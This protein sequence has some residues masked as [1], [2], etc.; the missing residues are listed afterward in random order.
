MPTSTPRVPTSSGLSNDV[1]Q[2]YIA[3][4]AKGTF[5]AQERDAM[6]AQ[7]IQKN[8]SIPSVVPIVSQADL[9]I[10]TTSVGSYLALLSTILNRSTSV[11]HY[12]LDVFTNTVAN[13]NASGT[14][15]LAND[16]NL[17]KRIAAAI[18]VME[19]PPQLAEQHLEVVRSMGALANAT[20]K[21]STWNGDPIDALTLADTFNKAEAYMETS[22]DALLA[23]AQKSETEHT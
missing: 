2:G 6:I 11:K 3:L 16:A 14:P 4:T 5:T 7:A 18:L 9:T 21:L 19:V 20:E 1:A 23:A 17:Y 15:E 22:I 12:E 8:V 13:D 10:G